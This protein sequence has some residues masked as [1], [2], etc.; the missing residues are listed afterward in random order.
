MRTEEEKEKDGTEQKIAF[1]IPSGESWTEITVF[2]HG[3]LTADR[4]GFFSLAKKYK[5]FRNCDTHFAAMSRKPISF[6]LDEAFNQFL[7]PV[8]K[9]AAIKRRI[10]SSSFSMMTKRNENVSNTILRR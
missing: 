2:N 4:K 8:W 6:M 7:T 5:S 3:A 1:K 10:I 9:K